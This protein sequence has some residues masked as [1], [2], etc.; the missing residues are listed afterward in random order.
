MTNI[1]DKLRGGDRR[2]IGRSDQVAK[3]ITK[4][5]KLFAQ[6]FAAMLDANPVVRMRAADA[7]EKASA[8]YPVL[9]QPHKRVIVNKIAVIPQQ[10]VRWH[11][12]QILPRLKLTPK[13]RNHAMSILFD[14][15]EDKSSIVKTFAMQAL[16]DFAQ[17][18]ARLRKRILPILEFLTA[19]GTPAMRA[20]GH[21]LLP[22]LKR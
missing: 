19:N 18:D 21:K 6:V 17:T 5:P 4:N 20:R 16:F 2:S 11:V 10:E 13:E 8:I 14:Y 1:V 3:Q 9:L 22:I 12:A 7:I 15:L